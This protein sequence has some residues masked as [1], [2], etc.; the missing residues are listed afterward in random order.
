MRS[1][2]APPEDDD[3]V[4]AV[5]NGLNVVKWKAFATSVCVR[6]TFPDFEDLISL[7]II[8]EMRMQGP[9]SGKGSGEQ[10]HA[11]YSTSG[12]GRGRNSRGRGGGRFGNYHQNQYNAENVGRARG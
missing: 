4:S 2:G 1:I 12:R 8:E 5:L 6:E 3:L 11:F 10:A 9:D 7:M